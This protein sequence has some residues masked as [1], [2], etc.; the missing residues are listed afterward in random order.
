MGSSV[1]GRELSRDLASG[2]LTPHSDPYL[3]PK[4]EKILIG[5]IA[6]VIFSNYTS[7]NVNTINC[8][9]Q[10]VWTN[11][12]TIFSYR[13][14]LYHVTPMVSAVSNVTVAHLFFKFLAK[15][16]CTGFAYVM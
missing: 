2:W 1:I 16:F 3:S 14:A 7:S 4:S 9:T 13:G 10:A 8:W 12:W 5:P 6:N 11:R 15:L